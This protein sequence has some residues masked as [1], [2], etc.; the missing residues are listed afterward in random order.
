MTEARKTAPDT[1]FGT[2]VHRSVEG[3]ARDTAAGRTP[4]RRVDTPAD[5]LN[6]IRPGRNYG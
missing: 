3:L 2:L 5:E 6:R 1:P 4:R